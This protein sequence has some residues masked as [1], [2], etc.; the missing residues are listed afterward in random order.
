M[1]E[2][3]TTPQRQA[4]TEVIEVKG[5]KRLLVGGRMLQ[6][7]TE[8]QRRIQQLS[9][10]VTTNLPTMRAGLD[11]RKLLEA[12]W[13]RIDKRIESLTA[14]RDDLTSLVDELDD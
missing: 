5:R 3:Q 11:A 8:V 4:T 13:D 12:A 1:A 9:E 6:R 10:A 14:L 7:K 2:A